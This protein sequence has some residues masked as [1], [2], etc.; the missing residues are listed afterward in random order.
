MWSS[1]SGSA[2]VLSAPSKVMRL[3]IWWGFIVPC[4][5]SRRRIVMS[6]IEPAPWWP[7]IGMPLIAAMSTALPVECSETL[8]DAVR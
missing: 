3:M 5:V 8:P 4:S 6:V 1:W 7:R 2:S